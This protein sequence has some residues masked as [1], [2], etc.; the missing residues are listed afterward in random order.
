MLQKK[1]NVKFD[2]QTPHPTVQSPDCAPVAANVWGAHRTC[3]DWRGSTSPNDVEF[4]YQ[5]MVSFG[6]CSIWMGDEI[7]NSNWST[8]FFLKFGYLDQ[9][10]Q[11]LRTYFA[12]GARDSNPNPLRSSQQGSSGRRQTIHRQWV[13]H[14]WILHPTGWTFRDLLNQNVFEDPRSV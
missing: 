4:P 10:F 7:H 14:L 3:C 2:I 9:S 1:Q 12:I 6:E 8:Y 5:P 11:Y 13:V